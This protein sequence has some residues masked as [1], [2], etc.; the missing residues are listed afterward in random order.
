MSY[1]N[2]VLGKALGWLGSQT[3]APTYE[4]ARVVNPT[5]SAE[6]LWED[7]IVQPTTEQ[8]IEAVDTSAPAQTEEPEEETNL[9]LAMLEGKESHLEALLAKADLPTGI[10][11][12]DTAHVDNGAHFNLAPAHLEIAD[13]PMRRKGNELLFA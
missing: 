7:E 12:L 8:T 13:D 5:N 2:T 6:V 11:E 10:A 3:G 9:L 4:R 1:T